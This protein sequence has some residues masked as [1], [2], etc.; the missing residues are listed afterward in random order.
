MLDD[1]E[2]IIG[3]EP[4][5]DGDLKYQL[6]LSFHRFHHCGASLIEVDGIQLAVTA[7]HCTEQFDPQQLLLVAGDIRLSDRSG[8]EQVRQVTKIVNHEDYD[9]ETISY[10]I[11]LVFFH[12]KFVLN[13][14]VGPIPLP[15][16]DQDT[17]GLI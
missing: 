15:E 9:P 8:K 16:Q 17:K 10:D 6:S 5:N 4:A 11:S 7:A 2:R 3:G 12:D 13:E 1:R 14:W